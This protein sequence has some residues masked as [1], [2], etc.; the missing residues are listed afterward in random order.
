MLSSLFIYN[1]IEEESND[2]K[3]K[4]WLE[5]LRRWDIEGHACHYGSTK[6]GSYLLFGA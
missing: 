4:V 6:K 5:A 3:Y 2:L 1:H